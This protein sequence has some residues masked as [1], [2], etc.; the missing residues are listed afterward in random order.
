M[1]ELLNCLK[2]GKQG[3][4]FCEI[5]RCFSL[6]LFYYS[7][8][9]YN[10]VRWKFNHTLPSV[11]AIRNWYSSVNCSPGYTL[12]AFEALAKMVN[13]ANGEEIIVNLV[14]DEMSIRQHCNYNIWSKQFEGFIDSGK[15]VPDQ[16]ALPLAKDALVFLVVGVNRSFKIPV[17]YFF[18]TGLDKHEKAAITN[19]VLRRLSEIGIIVMSA[20]F[21][22]LRTNI[23]MMRI[24][25]ANFESDI[26]YIIDPIDKNRKIFLFLDA[27]H[28]LKLFRNC[29]ATHP[30]FD[31]NGKKIEW[32]YIEMLHA[33]QTNLDWSLSNKITKSHIQWHKKMNV[34]IAAQTMSSSVADSL[35]FLRTCQKE[36]GEVEPTANH[37]RTNVLYYEFNRKKIK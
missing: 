36:F 9:A 19:E 26:A 2:N 25:G 10:Y 29:F 15:S 8:R 22:G 1:E 34:E 18:I 35:E 33:L 13:E 23:S 4:Q 11:S 3:H 31:G 6:T 27:C 14:F 28:M 16:S 32:R 5:V 30:L 7:V 21:D 37:L 17:A 24:L 12:N 20:T